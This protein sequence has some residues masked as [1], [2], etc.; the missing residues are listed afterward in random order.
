MPNHQYPEIYTQIL[1]NILIVVL[2]I[3]LVILLTLL[4]QKRKIQQNREMELLK[5]EM[6]KELLTTRV[7]IQENIQRELSMEIH[8]NVGQTLLLAN[9]NLTILMSQIKENIEAIQL[10]QESKELLKK[11]MEDITAVSRSMNPDRIVEI[12]VFNAIAYELDVLK[13]KNIL[14]VIIEIDEAMAS[15]W[16]LK[17]EIQLVLFRIYQ[18]GI[19]NI[20]K[21]ASASLVEFTLIRT[22]HGVDMLLKDN[23]VG[24]DLGLSEKRDGIGLRN[25]QKRVAI[26]NG[27]FDIESAPGKGTTLRIFIP[28]IEFT[29]KPIP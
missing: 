26:F 27:S 5:A 6:E 18:E 2:L 10:I 23:G 25:I 9:V 11:S 20:L 24:F 16:Q 4:Y 13:R 22:Q 7:E 19:K 3:G 15:D 17:P 14:S 1:A 29:V 12:G 28:S 21:Y 8:D